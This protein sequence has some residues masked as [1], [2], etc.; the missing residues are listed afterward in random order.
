MLSQSRIEFEPFL[1][2]FDLMIVDSTNEV[3]LDDLVLYSFSQFDSDYVALVIG[4]PGDMLEY[5]ASGSSISRN[6]QLAIDVPSGYQ[7][8]YEGPLRRAL[9]EDEYAVYVHDAPSPPVS[10][11]ID[12]ANI[13]GVVGRLYRHSDLSPTDWFFIALSSTLT[14]TLVCL[15]FIDYFT[16][17]PNGWFRLILLVLHSILTVL[18]LAFAIVLALPGD[19]IGIGI[20]PPVWWWI[21]LAVTASWDAKILIVAVTFLGLQSFWFR[22]RRTKVS[23][24]SG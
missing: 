1:Q 12:K 4:L 19:P 22:F 8:D 20:E 5:D 16:H 10:V 21:P 9:G 14:I 7:L 11:V 3:A 13:R 23:G 24:I 18:L 15:P 6:G 17:R 2:P